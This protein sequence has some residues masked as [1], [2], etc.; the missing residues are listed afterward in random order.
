MM[1]TEHH[2]SPLATLSGTGDVSFR[3]HGTALQG[4]GDF[5]ATQSPSGKLVVSF[6][7][8]KPLAD[9]PKDNTDSPDDGLSFIGRDMNGHLIELN[10]ET[11][12]NYIPWIF[13]PSLPHP[14]ELSFY[15]SQLS[16]KSN[17]V[18]DSRYHSMRFSLS[19]L[20]WHELSS[21]L[22]EPMEITTDEFTVVVEPAT[23]YLRVSRRLTATHGIE[24]TA[25]ILVRSRKDKS[26][27]LDEFAQFVDSLVH[28]F[29]LVTG[30]R[31]GCY[32]GHA[33]DDDSENILES[34][35][36]NCITA[37]YSN[38]LRFA[39]LRAGFISG[40][41]KIDFAALTQA[42]YHDHGDH[43]D[44]RM[45][46]DYFSSTCDDQLYL[47]MRGLMASTLTEL[48]V[49]TYARSTGNAEVIVEKQYVHEVLPL[50]KAALD[51]L[52]I[53]LEMRE[54]LVKNLGGAYRTTFRDRLKQ[55]ATDHNLPLGPKERNRIITIRN[56]LV[57][58]GT[59][60]SSRQNET[61]FN[62]YLF[63]TWINFAILCRLLGYDGQLSVFHEGG[64]LRI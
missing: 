37:P 33:L 60:P 41:P 34:I 2:G 64:P 45:L 61:W 17:H 48:L 35:Y 43:F 59:Y 22:P 31:V 23:D 21:R 36:N 16:A 63:M 52:D 40:S 1:S 18:T 19:N 26:F 38:T 7:P 25:S 11:S 57:H 58:E 50:V 42:F 9:M 24:P 54:Q 6:V 15:P 44:A 20:L 29:R 28:L 47:E 8:T 27:H 12:Y 3:D 14:N 62:D 49:A 30:N 13:S 32:S 10:G 51:D 46:I 4:S 39:P 55:L 56:S 5:Q 53:S